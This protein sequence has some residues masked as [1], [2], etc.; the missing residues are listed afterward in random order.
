MLP[1]LDLKNVQQE[2]HIFSGLQSVI[3]LNGLIIQQKHFKD[4][5]GYT[6]TVALP[7]SF[8]NSNYNVVLTA[9]AQND[10]AGTILSKTTNDITI[11]HFNSQYW[12]LIAIGY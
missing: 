6:E 7:I 11:Y 2:V 8:S 1:K 10:T 9:Y 3:K 12:D 4:N 5:G